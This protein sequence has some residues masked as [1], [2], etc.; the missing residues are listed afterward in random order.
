MKLLILSLLII[1]LITSELFSQKAVTRLP[2]D[3]TFRNKTKK[4]MWVATDSAI[5]IFTVNLIQNKYCQRVK[6]SLMVQN[7]LTG[8]SKHLSDSALTIRTSEALMWHNKLDSSD[9]KLEK[10][11]IALSK[12]TQCKKGWVKATFISAGA[13]LVFIA[14]TIIFILK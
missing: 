4:M 2:S 1:F 6:D 13:A 3:S 7:R 5:N 8:E 14:T 9:K 12:E 10:T 11:E